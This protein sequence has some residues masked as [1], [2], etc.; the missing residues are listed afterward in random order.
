[1]I[2]LCSPQD[3]QPPSM[4]ITAS[5]WRAWQL[6][7]IMTAHNPEEFGSLGWKSYP[8]LRAMMEMCITSQFV[9]PPPTLA[10]NTGT[11]NCIQYKEM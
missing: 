2:T 6:L 7:L 1:M 8:T 9:F 11:S 5:Y 4:A 3:Y 10:S